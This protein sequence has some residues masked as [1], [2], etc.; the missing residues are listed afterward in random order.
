MNKKE[1][2]E[3][4]IRELRRKA[5]EYEHGKEVSGLTI[6]SICNEIEAF[7]SGLINK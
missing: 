1:L 7:F 4:W 5:H 6:D 2:K 3:R